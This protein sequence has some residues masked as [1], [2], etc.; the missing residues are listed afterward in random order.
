MNQD[1]F[2]GHRFNLPIMMLKHISRGI[3]LTGKIIGL[4]QPE[5]K[6]GKLFK[7][8]EGQ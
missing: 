1:L 7:I 5:C 8:T 3:S 6:M 2:F 4:L